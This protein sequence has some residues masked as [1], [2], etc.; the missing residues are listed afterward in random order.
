MQPMKRFPFAAS[1]GVLLLSACA[2]DGG[3]AT[4]GPTLED[5]LAERGYKLGSTVEQIADY[6]V[7]GWNYIDNQHVIFDAGIKREYL[8]TVQTNCPG[9]MGA[10]TIAFT[11]TVSY[12]TKFDKL[13]VRDAGF[14]NQCPI[15]ELRELKPIKKP[16]A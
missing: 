14:D 11:S 9:L 10:D 16:G 7:D 13:I 1:I 6:R 8:V 15:V 12:V 4:K 3:G 5:R 2:S